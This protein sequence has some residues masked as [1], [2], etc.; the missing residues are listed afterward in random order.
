MPSKNPASCFFVRCQLEVNYEWY[1]P[2]KHRENDIAA[3][4]RGINA[5]AMSPS[6]MTDWV[7]DIQDAEISTFW[8]QCLILL[9]HLTK[10][11]MTRVKSMSHSWAT[12]V[13]SFASV[14]YI[15]QSKSAPVLT[16]WEHHWLSTQKKY[17]IHDQF[18]ELQW[19]S[20]EALC[21]KAKS[22]YICL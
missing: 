22:C 2:R 10:V 12:T 13:E 20:D 11:K 9:Y 7:Q 14:F 17:V 18:A 8:I 3:A 6:V 19:H 1:M 16:T 4:L 15:S 21:S 5:T